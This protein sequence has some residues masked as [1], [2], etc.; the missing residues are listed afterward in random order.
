MREKESEWV[1]DE[2]ERADPLSKILPKAIQIL[3]PLKPSNDVIL[4]K[5]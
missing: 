3:A 5:V 4:G 2:R 1:S